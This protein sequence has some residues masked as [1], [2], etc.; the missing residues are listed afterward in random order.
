MQDPATQWQDFGSE[1]RLYD[2]K[3]AALEGKILAALEKILS[4]DFRRTIDNLRDEW[5]KK[6]I[7]ETITG[8]LVLKKIFDKNKVSAQDWFELDYEKLKKVELQN[9]NLAKFIEEWNYCLRY[10][11]CYF[12]HEYLEA[13]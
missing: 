11:S 2:P 10:N 6:T 1:G 12:T 7:P 9:D 8:R 5:L 4:G 3:Y 13:Q